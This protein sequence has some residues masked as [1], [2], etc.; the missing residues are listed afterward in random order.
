MNSPLITH[1]VD[2]SHYTSVDNS[3]NASDKQVLQR[4]LV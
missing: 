3:L 2:S 1:M 4:N